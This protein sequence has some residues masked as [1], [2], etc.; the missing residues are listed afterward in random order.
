M[1]IF[2]LG[3]ATLLS[4]SHIASSD[5]QPSGILPGKSGDCDKSNSPDCCEDGKQYT[6][7]LCSPPAV[8]APSANAAVLTLNSFREG[9]DGGSP[10][11]CDNAFHAD[12]EL[13]VALS[14]GWFAGMAR[15]GRSVR[16]TVVPGGG[17]VSAKV[18]DECDSVHG[19]DAEHNFE[20]PCGNNVVDAS[21]AVWDALGLDRN[22][23]LQDITWSDE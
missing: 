9:K 19:C 14:T 17:S 21:P 16:I 3:L 22:Q 13:V 20:A 15:C 11:E 12:S 18:V 23:G 5:C 8:S 4:T 10:S 1:A 7:F 6:Q 2:F